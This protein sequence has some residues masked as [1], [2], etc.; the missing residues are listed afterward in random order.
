MHNFLVLLSGEI[1]RM[2]KYNILAASVFVSVIWI[3]VLHFVEIKDVSKI[4]P[5]LI[6]LDATSMAML[7][8]GVTIFFE[9]QEGTIKT[10]LVSPISKVEFILAKTFANILT[11]IESLV[12]LYLYA[13]FFKE[14]N[15]HVWGL[16]GAT[17]LIA[18]FHSLMGFML[19]YY[20]KDFTGLIMG[21]MKYA[22]IFMIPVLLEQVG[23]IKSEAIEKLLYAIPTKA[24][25]TLLKATAG[26]MAPWEIYL[27]IV[28]LALTSILLYV[29][30]L[31]QFDE[32]ALKESGV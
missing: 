2:K 8:V 7:L 9:K 19:T 18:F 24:S 29:F 4:F 21:M 1:Q 5:L 22:F 17:V 10:L 20:S 25:M 31:K 28:Y 23:L 14:I 32:F 12:I 3:G 30:V 15:I 11:T 13:I 16:L 26:G 27:S 6:W